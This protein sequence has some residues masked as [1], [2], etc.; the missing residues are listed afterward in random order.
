M[1]FRSAPRTTCA[2]DRSRS[3]GRRLLLRRH[4]KMDALEQAG[5]VKRPIAASSSRTSSW[6]WCLP[7]RPRRSRAPRTSRRS[8]N[9]AGRPRC[10]AGRCLRE[11][12]ARPEGVWDAVATKVIPT[13]DVRAALAAVAWGDVPA[14]IVYRTDAVTSTEVRI[15]YTV[16]NG[17][18]ITYSVAPMAASKHADAA[19]KFVGLPRIHPRDARLR[20]ARVPRTLPSVDRRRRLDPAPD[21]ARRRDRDARHPA[22]RHRRSVAPRAPPLGREERRRDAPRPAARAPADGGGAPPSRAPAPL[23]P[24]RPAASTEPASRSSSPGKPWSLATAVMSFPLLVRPARAAF[25]EI[26]P[27]LPGLARSLGR[28]PWSG[29]RADHAAARVARHRR[30][31]PSRLLPRARGVRR[32]DHRSPATSR[33]ARRRW[34]SRSSIARRSVR[35]AA[36]LRLVGVTVVIAFAAVSTTELPRAAPPPRR[37]R[38][39]RPRPPVAA[40]FLP[41]DAPRAAR[42]ARPSPCSALRAPARRRS[43][44][45]SRAC[46][47]ARG[48]VSSW[49]AR[50]S[51]TGRRASGSR[52]SAAGSGT[53]PQDS[54][55]FPHL[56][57]RRQRPIRRGGARGGRSGDRRDRLDPR[58][59]KP[60][61][62]FPGDALGRRETARRARPGARHPSRGCC[63][64]TSR[65]PAST[66]SS[67]GGSS[68]ISCAFAT[69]MRIPVRLR[70]AQ[71]RRSRRHGDRG[72]RCCARDAGVRGPVRDAPLRPLRVDP[73]ARFDNVVAG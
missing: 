40:R 50:S 7:T 66:S 35:I 22:A 71:R 29:L 8:R 27:R 24:R 57:V 37:Q 25:E 69:Q 5:L 64:S 72:A 70:H 14:G 41:L 65:S 1:S 20:A 33:G 3:S 61:R 31:P 44:N 23:G 54:L 67:A 48:A 52:P 13:L 42:R 32:D 15:A 62:P 59:R 43:S 10:S 38:R 12:V 6:S 46:G 30:G 39:D 11:E 73:D 19:A 16:T 47:A 60:P 34:R 51:R 49:M 68:R 56:D 45:R 36:A 2:S 55:L 9:R 21:A 18:A 26:D 63:S 53:C 17:P 58:D 28:G 4:P